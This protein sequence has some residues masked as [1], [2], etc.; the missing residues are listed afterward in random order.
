MPRG[1]RQSPKSAASPSQ[2]ASAR[3]VKRVAGRFMQDERRA[4]A[5]ARPREPRRARMT[6]RIAG[7]VGT[8]HG[9]ARSRRRRSVRPALRGSAQAR[10]GRAMIATLPR[11]RSTAAALR[12]QASNSPSSI[13][14][15]CRRSAS[16]EAR[17]AG[18]VEGR[19]HDHEVEGARRQGRRLRAPAP[20]SVDIGNQQRRTRP[21]AR[22]SA[23]CAS[24][25]A[26]KSAISGD[27]STR[28]T[29]RPGSATATASAGAHRRRRRNRQAVPANADGT[30]AARISAST[31][32]RWPAPGLHQP[33][34]RRG[35]RRRAC[36]AAS[37]AMLRL[38]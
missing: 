4:A 24:V 26:A 22:H 21:P 8:R 33:E 36:G 9:P 35:G 16:G 17:S 29:S 37:V 12:S 7:G 6:T 32:A 3:A 15:A 1:R 34:A 27:R 14:C 19:V 2:I 38:V 10:P 28:C 25:C 5:R 18:R 20:A 31:P 13:T 30:A 11:G 23:G